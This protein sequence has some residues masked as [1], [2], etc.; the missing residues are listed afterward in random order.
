M[1]QA[2]ETRLREVWEAFDRV[3][4][5]Y[6]KRPTFTPDRSAS[7]PAAPPAEARSSAS[8]TRQASR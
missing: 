4:R 3:A 2:R 8:P 1:E 5:A 6:P 7:T